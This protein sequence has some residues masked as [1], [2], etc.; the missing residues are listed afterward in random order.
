MDYELEYKLQQFKDEQSELFD[1]NGKRYS[2]TP[3]SDRTAELMLELINDFECETAKISNEV[4]VW[5]SKELIGDV[6]KHFKNLEHKGWD[7]PSFYNGW[8]EGRTKMRINSRNL[9]YNKMDKVTLEKANKLNDRIEKLSL[10]ERDLR[11]QFCNGVGICGSTRKND[12]NT[13][14]T[15]NLWSTHKNNTEDS[16]LIMKEG[17]RAMYEKVCLLLEEA[18]SDLKT[19]K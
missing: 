9:K 6:Q 7:W 5:G 3:I 8:I 12:S 17:I 1:E 10:M 4:K 19:L 14:Y 18:E 13:Y 2:N 15:Y 11:P 16:D